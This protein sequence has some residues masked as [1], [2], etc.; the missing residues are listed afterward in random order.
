MSINLTKQT[1]NLSK[2][3]AINLSKSSVNDGL[4]DIDVCLGWDPAEKTFGTKKHGLLGILSGLLA[5]GIEQDDIDC[6][7]WLG[8]Y[9]GQ[10]LVYTVYF[11]ALEYANPDTRRTV[12][13]HHGDNL[14]GEGK[15]DDEVISISLKD[16]PSFVSRITVG[17][18]IYMAQSRAQSFDMI[19]NLFIRVVDKRDNFE[20]CRF[21]NAAINEYRGATTFYAGDL[22][23]NSDGTWDFVA[24]GTGDKSG[25]IGTAVQVARREQHRSL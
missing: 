10:S 2:K 16:L 4:S 12:I 23:K 14:T 21:E 7:A 1:V 9:D 22:V 24:V 18:T 11:G 6:D 5:G 8:I 17:V 13:Q 25:T 20:I 15:G 3:Q 19:K